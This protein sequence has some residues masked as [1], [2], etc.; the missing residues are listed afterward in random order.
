MLLWITKNSAAPALTSLPNRSNEIIFEMKKIY[1]MSALF[2]ISFFKIQIGVK[3]YLTIL[4][5]LK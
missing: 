4:E 2:F 5:N 3:R 1:S